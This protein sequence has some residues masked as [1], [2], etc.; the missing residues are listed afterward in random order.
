MK[1]GSHSESHGNATRMIRRTTSAHMNGS[2]PLKT[3]PVLTS[4]RSVRSTNMFM[5]TGG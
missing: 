4:G 5:P 2:T 3:V 1:L